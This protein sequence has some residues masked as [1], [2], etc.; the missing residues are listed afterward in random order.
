MYWIKSIS[1]SNLNIQHG[2]DMEIVFPAG[3]VSYDNYNTNWVHKREIC[4][5]VH[6][7]QSVNKMLTYFQLMYCLISLFQWNNQ[8]CHLYLPS[9]SI[10]W[11]EAYTGSMAV[12]VCAFQ[13]HYKNINIRVSFDLQPILLWSGK[14]KKQK[15]LSLGN[16]VVMVKR[17]QC[18]LLKAN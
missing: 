7:I 16:S 13:N 1:F 17:M 18:W 11:S 3:K 14:V 12:F 15:W 8:I 4:N 9:K 6:C 2:L 5:C 10:F